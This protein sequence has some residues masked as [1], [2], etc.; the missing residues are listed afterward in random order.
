MPWS[1]DLLVLWNI[2]TPSFDEVDSEMLMMCS[3]LLT[4]V[5]WVNPVLLT[6]GFIIFESLEFE[7]LGL[8]SITEVLGIASLWSRF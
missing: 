8:E 7:T 3:N 2:S 6:A 5:D 1:T 4:A